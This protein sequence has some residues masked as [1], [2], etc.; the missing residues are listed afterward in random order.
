MEVAPKMWGRC[1]IGSRYPKVGGRE[2]WRSFRVTLCLPKNDAGCHLPLN[3]FPRGTGEAAA[4][5]ILLHFRD[6]RSHMRPNN[7][8]SNR[9]IPDLFGP[10]GYQ[11][12]HTTALQYTQDTIVT[13][14]TPLWDRVLSVEAHRV[15]APFACNGYYGY[16][17]AVSV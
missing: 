8:R 12:D 11:A 17:T 13:D 3:P 4:T 6:K 1:P 7:R 16:L 10:R 15:K 9:G 2:S 14:A 5:S